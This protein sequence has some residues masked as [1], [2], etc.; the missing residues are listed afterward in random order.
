MVLKL[1]QELLL[2]SSTAP[3]QIEG[4]AL[5]TDWA[6]W[7]RTPGKIKDS[8]TGDV[9]C[10]HWNRIEEDVELLSNMNHQI[11]R[12]GIEWARIQP[13][14]SVFDDA[15]LEQYRHEIQ[16]LRE[17]GI[18]PLVTLHHFV[19]PTWLMDLGGWERKDVVDR[20]V[21]YVRYV[22]DA[23]ADV[24]EEW[25]TINE[26]FVYV[27]QGYFWGIWPPGKNDA[28]TGFKVLRNMLHANAMAYQVIHQI[29]A[30]RG[31][32]VK[33]GIAHHMRNFDPYASHSM[34]DR[35][36]AR[37][38]N[39]FNNNLVLEGMLNGRLLMPLGTGQPWGPGPFCD[40]IGVN[41]YSRDM[42]KFTWNPAKVFMEFSFHEMGEK[43]DL[44]WELYPQG[45]YRILKSLGRFNMPIWVTE[46]GI[47]D[48][49]DDQRPGYIL[50][51]LYMIQKVRGEGVNVE[52]YYH[53]STMDNFEWAEG[54]SA[55][56]GL[57]EVNFRTQERKIRPSG[58]MYAEICKTHVIT[59]EML[60]KHAPELVKGQ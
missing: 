19:N 47:A 15:A 11:Y 43:N 49:D 29:Y 35:L 13:D 32:T 9:A 24:V 53:W 57:V 58:A 17:K 23:L 60:Q 14:S 6:Q 56:F 54:E 12:F 33:V 4:S 45:L 27:V 21:R 2:G 5:N 30:D 7:C 44:G 18:K 10:D 50:R 16:L 40:F 38:G 48:A 20:F 22:V 37:L 36:A 46:N 26:P 59:E 28:M 42:V 51:H 31:L 55:R 41:F 3:Y 25:V 1:D 8:T 52:R 39:R 34:F